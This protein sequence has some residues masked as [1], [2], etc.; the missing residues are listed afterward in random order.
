MCMYF[1][2]HGENLY[3][4]FS[5]QHQQQLERGT[6][7]HLVMVLPFLHFSVYLKL[8]STISFILSVHL[9]TNVD[10]SEEDISCL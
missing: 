7:F 9:S 4:I 1:E 10:E 5:P 2:E 8:K 6:I 3:V